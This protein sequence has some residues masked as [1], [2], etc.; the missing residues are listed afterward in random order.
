MLPKLKTA[1]AATV[2]HQ[3]LHLILPKPVVSLTATNINGKFR[4]TLP[5]P[6]VHLTGGRVHTGSFSIIF[7]ICSGGMMLAAPEHH[8]RAL[9]RQA[10]DPGG[11][12]PCFCA[13]SPFTAW[14][15]GSPQ[16]QWTAGS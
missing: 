16:V 1:I 14:T 11:N 8:P 7:N 3:P 4:I 10:D 9:P 13:G 5:A 12:T 2:L 15:T 6:K